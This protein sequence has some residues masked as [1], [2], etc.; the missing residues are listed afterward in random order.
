M[1]IS[2][3]DRYNNLIG[4]VRA[5]ATQY[6]AGADGTDELSLLT[7]DNVEKGQRLMWRDD[8]DRIAGL[9]HEMIVSSAR[10]VHDKRGKALTEVKAI[11][12]I[13]ELYWTDVPKQSGIYVP[14]YTGQTDSQGNPIQNGFVLDDL[15][16][17]I[18]N[19]TRWEWVDGTHFDIGGA[20]TYVGMRETYDV[21]VRE[22]IAAAAAGY[23]G[24]ELRTY[25]F[26]DYDTCEVTHRY[27]SIAY[28]LPGSSVSDTQTRGRFTYSKN[29][30]GVVRDVGDSECY[31]AVR[32]IGADI[33]D[34]D[35][36]EVTG[37]HEVYLETQNAAQLQAWG[38][39][40]PDG[41]VGHS[42]YTVT[43][44]EESDAVLGE[45]AA[46]TLEEVVTPD[47]TYTVDVCDMSGIRLREYV[48]VVD[49]DLGVRMR[50]RVTNIKQDLLDETRG[51]Q[52]TFGKT[53]D[54][55]AVA[56]SYTTQNAVTASSNTNTAR[57]NRVAS[58]GRSSDS[59]TERVSTAE[60]QIADLNDR[61][62]S[63]G[64]GGLTWP[65]IGNR[66]FWY[67][68]DKFGFFDSGGNFGISSE[69]ESDTV[70][71]W[72][73]KG[74]AI[75]PD[76]GT[77]SWLEGDEVW[78]AGAGTIHNAA[79]A[80]WLHVKNIVGD[81]FR[82][83]AGGAAPSSTHIFSKLMQS[84]G[85]RASNGL[86][87]LGLFYSGHTSTSGSS[88]TETPFLVVEPY[89]SSAS[90]PGLL[91]KT[92][93][94]IT[95]AL[96]YINGFPI[97]NLQTSATSA[98]KGSAYMTLQAPLFYYTSGTT[99]ASRAQL[100]LSGSQETMTEGTGL[101]NLDLY[102]QDAS[103]GTAHVGIYGSSSPASPRIQMIV[104]N[105]SGSSNNVGLGV[106]RTGI[107][108]LQSGN[109]TYIHNF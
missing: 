52:V 61:I 6:T 58:N 60:R 46:Q 2:W 99:P 64:S 49:E 48:D 78:K 103:N 16:E 21:S 1:V 23:N 107:Y 80:A 31:T 101:F 37:R 38:K 12:S 27:V 108:A 51:G 47:V 72:W 76:P 26:A 96:G 14:H 44:S 66:S 85:I 57:S 102:G 91:V 8:N 24:A 87:G 104:N 79:Q 4:T 22:I 74:T 55:R 25:V 92:Q 94:L 7:T 77:P 65:L 19:G 109:R 90:A 15:M 62:D 5:L 73:N 68:D 106:D 35:T 10:T 59:T 9:V 11:N 29:L 105:A 97:L 95:K 28:P 54:Y 70:G 36:G 88:T 86:R 40:M 42:V 100:K 45:I 43:S 63:G 89:S 34:P 50:A 13:A 98:V 32:A 56:T 75:D 39:P 33:T 93:S 18:L 83:T 71:C 20:I 67:Q 17:G 84:A 81:A 41:T 53:M 69:G 3:L 82:F 30:T